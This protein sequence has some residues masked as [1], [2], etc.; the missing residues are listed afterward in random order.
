MNGDLL[1]DAPPLLQKLFA[2]IR[3][4]CP[5][6][7]LQ[8]HERKLTKRPKKKENWAVYIGIFYKMKCI[9]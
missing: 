8:K 7:Y 5:V 6:A 4:A 2:K 9:T 1:S 3:I